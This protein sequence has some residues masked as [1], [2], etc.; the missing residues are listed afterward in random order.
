MHVLPGSLDQLRGTRRV[1]PVVRA[2]FIGSPRRVPSLLAMLLCVVRFSISPVGF[3]CGAWRFFRSRAAR[4]SFEHGTFP[5]ARGVF[6]PLCASF[7]YCA[8]RFFS[9]ARAGFY[10]PVSPLALLLCLACL[11]LLLLLN[12]LLVKTTTETVTVMASKE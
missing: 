12:P 10:H 11:I 4:F 7:F 9:F 3:S 1:H 6:F 8:W 5:I 2:A